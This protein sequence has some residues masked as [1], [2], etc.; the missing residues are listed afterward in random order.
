MIIILEYSI[1][2]TIIH[3]SLC[4]CWF[5]WIKWWDECVLHDKYKTW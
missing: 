3:Q 1:Q 5:S 4:I 2:Y